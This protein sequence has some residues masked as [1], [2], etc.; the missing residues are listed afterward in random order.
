MVIGE[1]CCQREKK[2]QSLGYASIVNLY[3]SD[4]EYKIKNLKIT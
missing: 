3:L 4:P 2:R 1:M